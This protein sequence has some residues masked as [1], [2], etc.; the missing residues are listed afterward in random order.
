MRLAYF[1]ALSGFTLAAACSPI[2]EDSKQSDSEVN[3]HP[4]G[5]DVT[6]GSLLLRSPVLPPGTTLASNRLWVIDQT[7]PLEL[8][9]EVSGIPVGQFAY[10]GTFGINAPT[11]YVFDGRLTSKVGT[12]QEI[13]LAGVR[14][15]ASG[16]TRTW[17]LDESASS[18]IVATVLQSSTIYPAK[19]LGID[20]SYRGLVLP[21]DHRQGTVV[22]VFPGTYSYHWGLGDGLTFSLEGGEVKTID[23]RSYS[24]RE[25]AR[26]VPGARNKPNACS[27][28]ATLSWTLGHTPDQ[29][30]IDLSEPV[31]IGRNPH[32]MPQGYRDVQMTLSLGCVKGGAPIVYGTEGA[33][34]ADLKLGRVDVSDVD[35]RQADGSTKKT[36]GSYTI[37]PADSSGWSSEVAG[38]FTTETGVDLLPGTYRVVV[39]YPTSAGTTGTYEETFTTP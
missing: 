15:D 14:L 22:P 36:R 31:E 24:Q 32:N 30:A 12:K 10:G 33:G 4:I 38:P 29:D 28:S 16:G 21:R 6:G 19:E 34:P 1:L 39:S 20:Q 3:I 2:S 8:D 9:R 27:S 26:I 5:G 17:G 37:H 18:S 13:R 23:P 25:V 35:V 7:H 11:P